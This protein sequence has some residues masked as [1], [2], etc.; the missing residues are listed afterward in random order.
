MNIRAIDDSLS[1]SL[2]IPCSDWLGVGELGRKHLETTPLWRPVSGHI[3]YL[4]WVS[5]SHPCQCRGLEI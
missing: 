1:Q 2:D 5:L 4:P 3:L